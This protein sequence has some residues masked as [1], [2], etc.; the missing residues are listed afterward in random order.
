MRCVGSSPHSAKNAL[1]ELERSGLLLAADARLPSLTTLVA[2]VPVRGSWW[3]HPSGRAIYA[4]QVALEESGL[5]T[6]AKLVDGKVTWVH[7]RLWPDLLRVG[8]ADEPWQRARLS[9]AALALLDEVREHGELQLAERAGTPAA[10]QR[11][12][13]AARELEARLLVHASQVHTESG[14]HARVLTSWPSWA[15]SLH[16]RPARAGVARA[17]AGFES[18]LDSWSGSCGVRARLPWE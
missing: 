8:S 13:A 12:L 14:A 1:A 2:G 9:R 6:T 15:A 11:S 4:A 5:A 3:G 17:R 16:L 18:I 10:R 7:R